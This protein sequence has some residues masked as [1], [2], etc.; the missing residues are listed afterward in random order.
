MMVMSE[1][2]MIICNA[3]M[4][5]MMNRNINLVG[6]WYTL[7]HG[8]P[9]PGDG[10]GDGDGDNLQYSDDLDDDDDDDVS[11]WNIIFSPT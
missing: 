1:K 9:H 4:I 8:L 7:L 11:T 6:Q 10:D 3:V 5:L 2:M